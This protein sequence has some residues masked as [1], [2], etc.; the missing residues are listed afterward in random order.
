[1]LGCRRHQHRHPHRRPP[2]RPPYPKRGN[3]EQ[4]EGGGPVGA[5]MARLQLPTEYHEEDKRRPRRL[6]GEEQRR[7]AKYHR[8]EY[9]QEPVSLMNEPTPPTQGSTQVVLR[10]SAMPSTCS[11]V[12]FPLAA[13]FC[14]LSKSRPSPV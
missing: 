7:R 9:G 14:V 12:N 4:S 10:R 3:D 2:F 1:M 11:G 13:K 8:H 6:A 5:R